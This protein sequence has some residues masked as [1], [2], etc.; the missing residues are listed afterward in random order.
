M[1]VGIPMVI[2]H[3]IPLVSGGFSTA[4]DG[5]EAERLSPV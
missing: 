5:D 2:D 4:K 1:I 3:I